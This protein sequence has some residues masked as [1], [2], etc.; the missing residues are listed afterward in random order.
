MTSS[1]HRV[2]KRQESLPKIP[3]N[4]ALPI[5][6]KREDIEALIQDNQVVVIAGETG[7]GKTTQIPKM[8]LSLGLGATGLIGHTQPRRIAARSVATRIAEELNTPLGD[9]IGYQVRFN[10]KVSE[11]TRVKLMT[12]G[13]LLAEL[14]RDRL[15]QKYEVIIIDEAH[16][17]SLNIDFL[18]GLL[19]RLLKKRPDLK[20]IIT[21]ATIDLEKFS[22]HFDNAPI[23]EVSGRT[24]PVEVIYQENIYPQNNHNN[25]HN[26]SYNNDNNNEAKAVDLIHTVCLTVERIIDSER[27]GEFL[28]SGDI[29]VF[30]SGEREIRD[31]AKA[32]EE[33]QLNL[34]VL[35]L[36][37]RLSMQEQTRVFKP[38]RRRKVVLATNVAETSITV[39]GIT[40]VIDPGQARISRYNFRSKVQGLP[41]EAISQAS[42]NQRMGRCG[43]VANGVCIRLYS[44]EDFLSRPEFT[45]AELLRSNLAAVILQMMQM[46]IHNIR[47]FPFIDQ[48]DNRLLND[49]F[50]LLEELQALQ[51]NTQTNKKAK[52]TDHRH[53]STIGIT[54]SRLPIDP[55]YAR[56]LFEANKRHCL[57][58]ILIIVA[59]LSI[60]DPREWPAD[61]RQAAQQKHA[62]LVHQKSDFLAYLNLW[63]TINEQRKALTNK[64]FKVF[65][66]KHFLSI[67]RIFEW[68]DMVG[69]LT[70]NIKQLGWKVSSPKNIGFLI[71]TD[72]TTNELKNTQVKAQ[73]KQEHKQT[74]SRYNSIHQ[75]LLSGLLGNIVNKDKNEYIAARGRKL[76]LFPTS[77]LAPK[78]ADRNKTHPTKNT[79]NAKWIMANEL[80]ETS[81]L[82]AL[83]CARIEPIWINEAA[84]HLL[85]YSYSNP[86]YHAKEGVVK[87]QRKSSLYGLNL[88]DSTLVVYNEIDPKESRKLFIQRA[89]VEGLYQQHATNRSRKKV[90]HFFTHNQHLIDK[91]ESIETKIRRRNLLISDIEIFRLFDEIIPTNIASYTHF[92]TWR[93]QVEKQNPQLLHLSCEQ[94][95]VNQ[96]SEKSLS[97]LTHFSADADTG[98]TTQAQFPNSLMIQGK[99]LTLS[100]HF[101]PDDIHD[102]ITISIPI[103]LLAPFPEHIGSWLVPGLLREKCIAL[104]KCLP[105]QYRKLFAPAA[106]AVDRIL[107]KLEQ[108]DV[109]LHLALGELLKHSTGHTIPNDAWQLDNLSDYYLLN[110]RLIFEGKQNQ[111]QSRNLAALK[112]KYA[113]FVTESLKIDN[114]PERK[115]FERETIHCWDF[116]LPDHVDYQHQGMTVR[117]YPMIEIGVNK[118]VPKINLKLHESPQIAH[119]FTQLSLAKL[120][121]TDNKSAPQLKQSL[122]YL[123]KEVF[124]PKSRQDQLPL[125][126][127]SLAPKKM[128]LQKL[129]ETVIQQALWQCCFNEKHIRESDSFYQAIESGRTKW[130]ETATKLE[131]AIIAIAKQLTPLQRLMKEAVVRDEQTDQN[132]EDIKNNVYSLFAEHFLIFTSQHQ[133]KQILR[134]LQVAR[135]RLEKLHMPTPTSFRQWQNRIDQYTLE[136]QKLAEALEPSLKESKLSLA[137]VFFQKPELHHLH[138][139]LHEWHCSLFAQQL[140]TQFPI[141]EN[142]IEK[143]WQKYF[144]N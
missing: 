73:N 92:E 3:F 13:V 101:N 41:I 67:T 127:L 142:R 19:K 60:Q 111:I 95:T 124:K 65:C 37:A 89:L 84:Q 105:K 23:I 7:S 26:S 47:Q 138:I 93:K 27:Q 48:P 136:Q 71:Q 49:G 103:E 39:P 140:R 112:T 86:E 107:P 90:A 56:M 99:P 117:A 82:F 114:A 129:K 33:Y 24:F 121:L 18:L 143:Y 38:A 64:E 128:Q 36:Y 126:M 115:A 72:Y 123:N 76:A 61:K 69:Q 12:D 4:D 44:E 108:A 110:Y 15:L 88:Q 75:S 109:A 32:L 28:A 8:C 80:M 57:H 59:A 6:Q 70:K 125:L 74:E 134:Y 35:P 2:K 55:K 122:M 120:A 66:G 135:L 20:L 78:R 116:D 53:L 50:K 119:F 106:N 141:S 104:I 16:E 31:I 118:D 42:A 87:V 43:R 10:D 98:K 46:G 113:K 5:N 85:R 79:A 91:I 144:S 132:L 94:L 83:T 14:Q 68:R 11:N 1:Q 52:S 131:S 9:I 58:E 25:D 40:Y 45:E 100:Y 22:Q 130:V 97:N 21:S 34:E 77:A 139:M 133:L 51:I 54:L 17:R 81:R 62:E 29:L 137:F 30:C 96:L 102:G 63:Q